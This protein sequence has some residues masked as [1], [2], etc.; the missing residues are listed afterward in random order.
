MFQWK[1]NAGWFFVNVQDEVKPY[2]FCMPALKMFSHGVALTLWTHELKWTTTAKKK[3]KERKY[4]FK[5][6]ADM[7]S[8]QGLFFQFTEFLDNI[9]SGV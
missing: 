7:Q 6:Y 1:E 4:F 3:K 9:E 5:A 2:I 8:D